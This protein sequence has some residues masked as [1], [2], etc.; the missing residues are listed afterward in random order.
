MLKVSHLT[1][2][3]EQR[4]LFSDVSFVLPNKG[5]CTMC[6]KEKEA[7]KALAYILAGM[8][9]ANGGS[10]QCHNMQIKQ[11]SVA[12]RSRYRSRY[13]T[14]WIGDFL[15]LPSASVKDNITMNY[16]YEREAVEETIRQ[17]QLSDVAAKSMEMLP[18]TIKVKTMLARIS[19]R[20]YAALVFYPD[21]TP[22]SKEELQIIY[23]LLKKCSESMLVIVI[24][25]PLSYPFSNR[26]LEFREGVLISDNGKNIQTNSIPL[27]APVKMKKSG[28]AAMFA[29]QHHRYRWPYHALKFLTVMTLMLV[30]ILW[31]TTSLDIINIEMGMLQ[32]RDTSSFVIHK[33]AQGEDGTL[34]PSQKAIMNTK[35]IQTLE[36]KMKTTLLCSYAPVNVAFAN[37]YLEGIYEETAYPLS[38]TFP[39]IEAKNAAAAD[40]KELVGH[41]PTTYD[42]VAL[43]LST[44]RSILKSQEDAKTLLNATISWYGLPLRITGIFDANEEEEPSSSEKANAFYVKNGYLKQHPLSQMKSF[45][46][47]YKRLLYN[48]HFLYLSDIQSIDVFSRYYNGKEILHHTRIQEDEVV[49]DLAGAKALGFPYEAY[50]ENDTMSYEEKLEEYL[51]FTNELIQQ[52][53]QVQAYTIEGSPLNSM[54]YRKNLKIAGF[55]LPSMDMLDGKES[56]KEPMIYMD[57]GGLANVLIKNVQI[58][59]VY[60]HGTLLEEVRGALQ[61]LT[62]SQLYE[63]NLENS[64]L[65]QLLVIDFKELFTFFSIAS[66]VFLSGSV[67]LYFTL[68][69]KTIQ[70]QQ[71]A[72]STYYVFGERKDQMRKLYEK[73]FLRRWRKYLFASIVLATLMLWCYIVLILLKLSADAS[74]L[75]YLLL[76][77]C[78]AG[79]LYFSM[80]FATTLY[81]KHAELL[82]PVYETEN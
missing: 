51:K 36:Q 77:A 48:D 12:E 82:L 72:C 45:P 2:T 15:F 66:L 7:E 68:L 60:Y 10:I 3:K 20:K 63:V 30:C 78:I 74:L 18:F 44:A 79:F 64:L 69:H 26:I 17:W 23:Q 37:A 49:L 24:G 27:S 62:D 42:E 25:D 70:H 29:I 22:Y 53:V 41:Y 33:V 1:V 28:W 5:F 59:N 61:Y 34:Y 80:Q 54:L 46:A 9:E 16:A 4:H 35:D 55:L 47:S 39:I 38:N 11:F 76:P 56:L 14:S 40:I 81:L 67:I 73:K 19:L 21:S 32:K 43:S 58:Q 31:S 65:L 50:A 6:A 52:E 75:A 71:I 57:E 13:V 8:K